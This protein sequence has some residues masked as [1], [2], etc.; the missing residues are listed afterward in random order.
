MLYYGCNELC[1]C[2]YVGV[3]G[4]DSSNVLHGVGECHS[5]TISD[6][7]AMPVSSYRL[8]I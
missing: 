5:I 8:V 3:L 7:H 4:V 1:V 6:V 2:T